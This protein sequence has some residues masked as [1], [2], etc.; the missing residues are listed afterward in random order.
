MAEQISLS[1]IIPLYNE[2]ASLPPLTHWI[3]RVLDAHQYTYEIIFIDDGSTDRSWKVIQDLSTSNTHIKAL[4]FRKNYGKSAA[5]NAGFCYCNGTVVVTLDADLQD[6]PEEIPAL[7]DMMQQKGYDIVSGWK[8]KRKDT[9]LKVWSSKFFNY[10][11]RKMSG[12]PL[13]DFNCGLKAY[14]SE[15]VKSLHIYGEMHRFIPVIAYWN[16][17]TQ[18]G[19]KSV[20][21]HARR[22]GTTKFGRERFMRGFL[23]LLSVMFVTKFKKRPMH[24][25]GTWGTIA[26]IAGF[27]VS[28]GLIVQKLYRLYYSLPIRD[29][30]SQT[31]FFLALVM[32]IVGVQLFLAGFLGEILIIHT[33]QKDDYM[34]SNAMGVKM[35]KM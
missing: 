22:Y 19:E 27:G 24:F 35:Q 7:Y 29:V 1:I 11:T 17:F 28:F 33:T 31:L 15:V 12:I 23:D 20:T 13:H 30:T 8:K 9:G 26:F 5:L 6:S 2:H 16:G 3:T 4:R 10:V 25:F 34:V 32:S 14:R 21:H 18:I